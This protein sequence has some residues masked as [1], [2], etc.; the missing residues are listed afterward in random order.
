MAFV[1]FIVG[2]FNLYAVRLTTPKLSSDCLAHYY[3]FLCPSFIQH[4]CEKFI[5]SRTEGNS[6]SPFVH[7]FILSLLPLQKTTCTLSWSLQLS[8]QNGAR[9]PLCSPPKKLKP[10]VPLSRLCAP[11][12]HRRRRLPMNPASSRVFQA[13]S[14]STSRT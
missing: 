9:F 3:L 2:T 5:S 7:S 14:P 4:Y 6:S 10:P 11:R 12:S 13:S 8:N 1:F